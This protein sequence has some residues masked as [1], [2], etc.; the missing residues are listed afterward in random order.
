M[1]DSEAII[2]TAVQTDNFYL[3]ANNQHNVKWRLTALSD[4]GVLVYMN[5]IYMMCCD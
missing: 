3:L 1:N 2:L 4:T 5:L